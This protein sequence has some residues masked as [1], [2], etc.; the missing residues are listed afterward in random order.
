MSSTPS[1][2]R[3]HGLRTRR[4]LLVPVT[5]SIARA[6]SNG[7]RATLAQ[8]VGAQVPDEWPADIAP[9]LPT[10]ADQL[11]QHA[12]CMGWGPWLAIDT[13]GGGAVVGDLGF[14]GKPGPSG[15]AEI[16]FSTVSEC[17]DR[18]IA[19]EAASRLLRWAS[20]N[21]AATVTAE[22]EVDNEAS[23]R[24]LAKLGM[25]QTG[26]AGTLRMWR[27]DTRAAQSSTDLLPIVTER[28]RLRVGNAADAPELFQAVFGD[29]EV[30]KFVAGGPHLHLAET[31]RTLEEYAVHQAVHG[32]SYWVV[33]DRNRQ[34]LL[35]DCGFYPFQGVG[36]EVELGFTLRRDTW[37]HGIATEIARACVRVACDSL[38]LE[39]IV[40][41]T[42]PKNIAS[43]KVL[44]R[45][46]FRSMGSVEAYGAPHLR[47]ALNTGCSSA[48]LVHTRDSSS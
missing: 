47:F 23:A 44:A 14:K 9:M 43:T 37:G 13:A 3:V 16:G 24:V 1:L 34:R 28:C 45:L 38:G 31:E 36:P 7:D 25:Q 19:T 33:E 39:D 4:L 26:I 29:S 30:M 20:A 41:V 10:W 27:I 8:A 6:A 2:G 48:K 15:C 21:G 18:G 12:S 11:A 17:R 42:H 46:G 32:Y 5:G 22:C 40:A 35:G